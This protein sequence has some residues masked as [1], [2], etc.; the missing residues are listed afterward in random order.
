MNK[1]ITAYIFG[2]LSFVMAI[3][4]IF[5]L[6]LSIPGLL[7]AIA[8]LKMPEKKVVIPIGYQGTV[9]KKHVTAR[10]FITTRYLAYIALGLN[11]F[12]IAVSLF[13]TAII[14]ALFTAGAR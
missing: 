2:M 11:V 14:A 3:T 8:S 9:G 5:S 1:L 12:S 4:G 7:L 6:F 13:A 10:P